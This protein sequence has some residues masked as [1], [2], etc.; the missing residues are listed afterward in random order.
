MAFDQA[1][2]TG[3]GKV[4]DDGPWYWQYSTTDAIAEVVDGYFN[5]NL[6]IRPGDLVAVTAVDGKRL[7]AIYGAGNVAKIANGVTS[8][9]G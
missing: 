6:G 8:F 9:F 7:C 5:G 4:T 3:L 1:G 2:L